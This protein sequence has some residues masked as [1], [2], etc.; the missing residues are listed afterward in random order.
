MA[1]CHSCNHSYN[2][3]QYPLCPYCAGVTPMPDGGAQPNTDT[4]DPGLSQTIMPNAPSIFAPPVN[5]TPHAA[6][7]VPKNYIICANCGAKNPRFRRHCFSCLTALPLFSA[8]QEVQTYDYEIVKSLD[9]ETKNYFYNAGVRMYLIRYLGMPLD[10]APCPS[11]GE[12]CSII[13]DECPNCHE[14]RY[15]YRCTGKIRQPDNSEVP[16]NN[17]LTAQDLFCPKCRDMTLLNFIHQVLRG[18][19]RGESAKKILRDFERTFGF[20][21]FKQTYGSAMSH[22]EIFQCKITLEQVCGELAKNLET[23]AKGLKSFTFES[24]NVELGDAFSD[25]RNQSSTHVTSTV[26]TNNIVDVI[27]RRE[28]ALSSPGGGTGNDNNDATDGGNDDT[29][30]DGEDGGD[31][32]PW[33]DPYANHEFE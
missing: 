13:D 16:C 6:V 10:R 8:R 11:C 2:S 31:G 3:I 25:I 30:D 26:P 27:R 14:M 18:E 1:L 20:R 33:D 12:E 7:H 9:R 17:I 23:I 5:I 4:S 24:R 15:N 29:G 22:G 32:D 28:A 21:L 19:I